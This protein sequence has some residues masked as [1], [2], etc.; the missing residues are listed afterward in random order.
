M[1]VLTAEANVVDEH[2]GTFKV[3][4]QRIKISEI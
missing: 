1:I 2:V 4:I 3:N